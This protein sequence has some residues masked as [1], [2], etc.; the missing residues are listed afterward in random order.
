MNKERRTQSTVSTRLCKLS[1][2]G[3]CKK[4]FRPKYYQQKFCKPEHQAK[5]WRIIRNE[6]RMTIEML[7]NH[8]NRITELEKKIKKLEEKKHGK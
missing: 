4:R 6:K 7:G 1:E 5:Y 3:K 8:E 2:L